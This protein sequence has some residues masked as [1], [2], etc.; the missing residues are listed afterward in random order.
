MDNEVVQRAVD[1]LATFWREVADRVPGGR[2][3]E[4]DGI[5]LIVSGLPVPAFNG[6]WG[7]DAAVRAETVLAAVDACLDDDLPWNLQLRPGHPQEL[8][9]ELERRGLV[10]TAQIPLMVLT[11][12]ARL[13]TA[14]GVDVREMVTFADVDAVLRLLERGFGMPPALTREAMPM[15]MFFL[16]GAHTWIAAVDG[17]EVSTALG[18]AADR[19]VGIYNVG[20]PEEHRRKGYGAIVTAEAVRRAWAAGCDLAY[21]QSSPMGTRVYER[22]G[23]E[24]A[25]LWT[26]WMPKQYVD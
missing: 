11:D 17:V 3:E 10:V 16:L 6:L 24:I 12:P 2:R 25:E 13:P 1:A 20:T 7:F 22:I 8:D 21:L 9:A 23:F 26:Q 15:L 4:R 18:V 14:A 5:S 19:V